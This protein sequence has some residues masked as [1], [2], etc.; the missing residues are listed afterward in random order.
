M[1]QRKKSFP[2]V[3]LFCVCIA[4]ILVLMCIIFALDTP[5]RTS[6]K[7]IQHI[8]KGDI[9]A[10][11][12]ILQD[13]F[14]PNT[15][16]S[17][18]SPF[19]ALFE[20]SSKVPLSVACYNGDLNMVQLLIKYGATG[21]Y[22]KGTG[23]SPLEM[24]LTRYQTEDVAIIKLLLEAGADPSFEETG[25]LPV[26]E[27]AG[28]FPNQFDAEKTNGTAFKDEYDPTIAQ[29]ITDIVVI[30]LGD[31]DVNIVDYLNRTLLMEA[32]AVGNLYL[33]DY[34][35]S[36]G[37]DPTLQDVE[38]R[39]AYDYAIQNNQDDVAQLLKKHNQ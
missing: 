24:T 39:T 36:I 34:L 25:R 14:D 20:I 15:P 13:G 12:A 30:L 33:V 37:A 21:E 5:Y 26:F 32:V 8:E 4:L 11:E 23:W 10:V 6:R 29:G 1:K 9:T 3:N 7:L 38:G 2:Y 18:P 28:M 22:Q 19:T 16:T 17:K 35:L 27:A 31:R